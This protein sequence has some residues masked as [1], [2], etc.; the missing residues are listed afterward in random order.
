MI[1]F[2]SRRDNMA[3]PD[4][5]DVDSN[6]TGPKLLGSWA[7]SETERILRSLLAFLKHH[8]ADEDVLQEGNDY[9]EMVD[10]Q[11]KEFKVKN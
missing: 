10:T 9:V 6:V 1:F 11:K 7:D 8:G 5:E 2:T 4:P 3:D